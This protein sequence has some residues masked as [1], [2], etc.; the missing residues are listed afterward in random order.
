MRAVLTQPASSILKQVSGW[1]ILYVDY[2]MFLNVVKRLTFEANLRFWIC[3]VLACGFMESPWAWLWTNL[4]NQAFFRRGIVCEL[5]NLLV[6]N[7]EKRD[8]KLKRSEGRCQLAIVQLLCV[9]SFVFFYF[10][11]SE[12]YVYH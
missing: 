10:Q 2:A 4:G 12:S 1:M 3:F 11:C 8:A 5:Y 6:V 7:T 9:V